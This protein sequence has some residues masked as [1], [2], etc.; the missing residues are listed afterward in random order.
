MVRLTL[1]ALA[2]W[3]AFAT[4]AA[5]PELSLAKFL[6]DKKA[7]VTLTFDDGTRDHLDYALPLLEK[8]G[9]KGT[10]FLV[11]NRSGGRPGSGYIC[12]DEW[13][14]FLAKGHE[15]SNHSMNHV[16]LGKLDNLD[17][18]RHEINAP[19]PIIKNKLGVTPETFCYPY[20]DINDKVCAIAH[21]KHLMATER[22]TF[23]GGAAFSPAKSKSLV[24]RAIAQRKWLVP[25]LHGIVPESDAWRPFSSAAVLDESLA[26]IKEKED[27]LWTDTF[28]QVSKYSLLRDHSRVK[29]ASRSPAEIDFNVETDL[30]W[31]RLANTPLTIVL[32]NY[33][34]PVTARQ[35]NKKLAVKRLDGRSCFTVIPA[36]GQ[37][38]LKL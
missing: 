17:S 9:L 13:K 33:P 19:I 28:T 11:V 26:Y 25:V 29:I 12:W 30:A 16:R 4:L 22:R 32:R 18:V 35:G 1:G 24:D 36:A 34:C 6:D 10:F 31:R 21:E 15:V 5:T 37:V 14:T 8:H 3:L 20:T 38:K 23:Y 27:E 2:F 7:A